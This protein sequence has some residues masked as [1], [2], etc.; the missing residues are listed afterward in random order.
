MA[1]IRSFSS[2]L[3][4]Y[5]SYDLLKEEMIK[6][7]WLLQN[8]E[9]D[10]GWKGGTLP[11][12]FQGAG[13]SSVSFG[14]LTAAADIA[15]NVYVRGQITS[16]P[17]VW[18]SILF[19][20]RDLMEHDGKVNE[21]S[22]L[23][24]LPNALDDFLNYMKQVVSLSFLN[25][26][27]FASATVDGTAGG[28]LVVDRI[29]RFTLNQK[30]QVDDDD[31]APVTGYVRT[32]DLNT[33]TVTL[34]DARTGGAAVDLSAYT[35]AQNAKVYFDNAQLNALTSLKSSLLSA[36]NGGSAALY[37]QTKTA[38]PYLQAIQVDGSAVTAA[39]ILNKIFDG[40]TT[41]KNK[42][43]GMPNQ[44]LMSYKNLGS[45]MKLLESG[46]SEFDAK[47]GFHIKQGSTDVNVY[48]WTS[49]SVF[50]VQGNLQVVGIQE[51]DDD[52]IIYMDKRA[53]K[54]HSNGFF[55]KRI[56]PDGD[57]WF[58]VRNTT[59]YQYITDVCFFGDLVL[60][61]PS[62]CGIM[63]TVSY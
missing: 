40:Y 5:L 18:G 53:A 12:P 2:M 23:K 61:R 41:V 48:G 47:G 57:S 10:M 58:E 55:K 51:I 31:S 39:N 21:K 59:G 9:K 30:V 42:G 15:E 26:S 13:A 20:Q 19:N 24:L 14:S 16:Q 25:G 38:F 56:N 33:D 34:F 1:T 37:G 60:S 17:E 45:V 52:Y 35:V 44:I 3:N 62:Y 4:E 49:I 11:V 6:R 36:A 32:I 29:E 54:I 50:G 8:L 27:A 28:A 7:D 43:K 22:F 63:H 46:S